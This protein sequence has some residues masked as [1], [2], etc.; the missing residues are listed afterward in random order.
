MPYATLDDIN[1]RYPGEL[2]QAGP[3]T[4]A[5]AVDEDAVDAAIGYAAQVID[6]FL[7]KIGAAVPL[8]DPVPDWIREATVD[9]ALYLATP[10]AVAS[11][12]DFKDR[13][14]RYS[15]ALQMLNDIAE[16]KRI[17]PL[18]PGQASGGVEFSARERAF[19]RGV[20]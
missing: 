18:L 15:D 17:A 19:T 8:S 2:A 7:R 10:T 5:G 12:V 13:Y 14:Q 4:A 3:K 9:M 6:A 16:G 20:L 1:A 11:Q